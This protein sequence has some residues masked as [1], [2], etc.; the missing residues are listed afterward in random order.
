MR[1]SSK[2]M[3]KMRMMKT[4]DKVNMVVGNVWMAVSKE[5]GSEKELK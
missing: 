1:E 2:T 4:N 3:I 5:Q